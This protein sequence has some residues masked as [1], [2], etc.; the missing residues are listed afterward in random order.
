[1]RRRGFAAPILILTAKGGVDDRVEG[2]DAGAD[3][4][5]VKPFGTGELLARVRALLR[6]VQREGR[7]VLALEVGETRIDFA[8]QNATRAGIDLHL[9][10]KELAMLRLLAEAG[11]ET[12]SRE[13]FLD[14]VWGYG[15]FPT[16]R[17]VDNHIASLRAKPSPN[18]R[19]TRY[20]KTVHG[21][22]YRLE[23]EIAPMGRRTRFHHR[24][25]PDRRDRSDRGFRALPQPLLRPA[26]PNSLPWPM[27]RVRSRRKH[28]RLA[29]APPGCLAAR[30]STR[31]PATSTNGIWSRV[32]RRRPTNGGAFTERFSARTRIRSRVS[33][34]KGIRFQ[35]DRHGRCHT[36][37]SPPRLSRFCTSVTTRGERPDKLPS[38]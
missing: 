30:H 28:S 16:T 19:P 36:A 33:Q 3:D 1:L 6:R 9:T 20:L 35:S 25:R 38:I 15:A 4:Y 12:V 5:L 8:R 34:R 18:R 27:K 10:A 29:V 11:G 21:V 37:E 31:T 14:V 2:L 7:V 26:G 24:V 17:T 23:T 22:G 13:R 32:S